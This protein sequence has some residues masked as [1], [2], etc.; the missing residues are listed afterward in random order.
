VI[1]VRPG[2]AWRFVQRDPE[3]NEYGFRGEYRE[4]VPPERLV[5]TLT[6]YSQVPTTVLNDRGS[7]D[8]H[9][10]D[11]LPEMVER[12]A[13]AAGTQLVASPRAGYAE[14]SEP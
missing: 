5:Y 8:G 1:D 11:L 9:A 3:G 13:T 4:V 12:Y 10:L 2:G 6:Y 14:F 7:V